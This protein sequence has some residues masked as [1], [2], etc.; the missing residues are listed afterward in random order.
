MLGK[1]GGNQ[2][3][4]LIDIP[5]QMKLSYFPKDCHLGNK[6]LFRA[7]PLQH[8]HLGMTDTKQIQGRIWQSHV[9]SSYCVKTFLTFESYHFLNFIYFSI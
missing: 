6:L 2:N 8:S 7:T 5:L 1:S 3:L 9:K 4:P